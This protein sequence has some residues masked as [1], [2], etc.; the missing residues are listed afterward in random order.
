MELLD[1]I[2]GSLSAAL[3]RFSREGGRLIV[4][5][6][7]VH[8]IGFFEEHFIF[9]ELEF[10]RTATLAANLPAFGRL[11]RPAGKNALDPCAHEVL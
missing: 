2:N 10:S 1:E 6:F 8:L 7:L 9:L 11:N 5:K 3:P 4:R